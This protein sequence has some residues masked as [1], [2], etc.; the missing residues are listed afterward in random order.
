MQW[1]KELEELHL[2]EAALWEHQ[3]KVIKVVEE[4]KKVMFQELLPVQLQLEVQED[5]QCSCQ[6]DQQV[7][8]DNQEFPGL[9]QIHTQGMD[10][11]DQRTSGCNQ[12]VYR[13]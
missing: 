9:L 13:D 2:V 6:L 11:E 8:S 5:Q 12:T 10:L 7:Q 4:I 1:A 3:I